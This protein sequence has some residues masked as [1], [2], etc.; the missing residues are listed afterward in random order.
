MIGCSLVMCWGKYDFK[1]SQWA[2]GNILPC[3]LQS[4]LSASR[5]L[6]PPSFPQNIHPTDRWTDRAIV[7]LTQLLYFTLHGLERA[8]LTSTT[9]RRLRRAAGVW[10]P[11]VRVCA[12]CLSTAASLHEAGCVAPH[13]FDI[14]MQTPEEGE[15]GSNFFLFFSK[16]RYNSP[17]GRWRCARRTL[18]S[19]R[20]LPN[21]LFM[22]IRLEHNVDYSL[23][24]SSQRFLCS[25]RSKKFQMEKYKNK[26]GGN[27][28]SSEGPPL[29]SQT[30]RLDSWLELFHP[31]LLLTSLGI[32]AD[33][34]TGKTRRPWLP[35]LAA[36]VVSAPCTIL[37]RLR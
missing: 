4:S 10:W 23:M 17:S 37:L 28:S 35:R 15:R 30:P 34:L 31:S 14:S 16:L 29:F 8:T 12:P 25:K 36:G 19:V 27:Q 2:V 22:L 11:C 1:K 9:V 13:A 20:L 6:A 33:L 7:L 21:P 26:R 32:T 24:C 3:P 18:S 5:R